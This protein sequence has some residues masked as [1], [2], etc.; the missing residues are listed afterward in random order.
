MKGRL[1]EITIALLLLIALSVLAHNAD[2]LGF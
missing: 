1:I 2:K